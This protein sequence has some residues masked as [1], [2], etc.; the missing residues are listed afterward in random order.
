[1]KRLLFLLLL[2][3]ACS[4]ESYVKINEIQIPVE[5]AITEQDQ[6]NG[7]MFRENL[8][9]GMLFV[10][11]EEKGR[12]FWMK[13]TWIPLDMVFIGADNKI[14]TIHHATPCKEEPCE[15]YQGIAQN[16][17]ELPGEFTNNNGISV[18]DRVKIKQ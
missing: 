18:G 13:N 10:Y 15:L 8:N 5:L 9:G 3:T 12:T 6:V 2:I 14:T 16:V 1:V 17:L 11:D 4:S 7:L